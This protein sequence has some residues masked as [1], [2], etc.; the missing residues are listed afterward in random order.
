[1][2]WP[3]DGD[4]PAAAVHLSHN[5]DVAFH[6]VEVRTGKGLRP[7]FS[8]QVPQGTREAV[9]DEFRR[10]LDACRGDVGKRKRV[11]A[12]RLGT[13]LAK[14]WEEGGSGRKAMNVFLERYVISG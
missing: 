6:L 14:A 1:M 3:F 4:Q 11:N 10:T 7:L 5:L 8:G 13:D 12:R 9:G 2:C